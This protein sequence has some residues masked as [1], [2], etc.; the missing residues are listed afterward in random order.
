MTGPLKRRQISDDTPEA[1]EIR[2]LVVRVAERLQDRYTEL[3]DS[4]NAAIEDAIADLDAPELT[5]MLHAS[6]EGNI[7]TILHMLRNGIPIEHVQ[8]ATAATEYAVRLARAGVPAASLRRA[9]HIG[10]DDLLAEVFREIQLLDCPSEL[11]LRLLHHLAG[12][13]HHYVD[14]ITRVVLDVHEAER[15]ALVEQNATDVSRLVHRVLDR[16]PVE[17][18]QFARTTGYRLDRP[19]VATVLWDE[20]M[21]QAADQIEALRSLATR[22][23]R[24][25]GSPNAPLFIPIDRSTAWVWCHVPGATSS[26]DTAQVHEVLAEAPAVRAAMGAHVVGIEG[27]RR[28]LEQANA[29]RIVASTSSAPHTRV[30]SY[31]DDGM[32][33]VAMLARDLPASRQWV[34]DALGT[35]AVDAEPA[36]RLRETL[37]TFLRTGS[38]VDT[39]KT[40][41]LHRNTVKY[42]LAKAEQER[43]RPLTEGRLD[44]ELALH[45]CHVLGPA[46]LQQ[47][48]K[49][50]EADLPS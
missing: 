18:D 11:K 24:A 44:L 31:G 34:V 10:S 43:G 39:S 3:S 48:R 46:V 12:W 32:A 42:R 45:L 23:T 33:L 38:Y 50:G 28:T 41:M 20:G 22:L 1:A 47:S 14:W 49:M 4:M 5:E 37:R 13:L 8:P 2:A 25:L 7:T 19:H 6:V 17:P 30:V 16:E 27:F 21:R 26:V 36:D 40:L 9:Y 29:V 35:L 15:Q